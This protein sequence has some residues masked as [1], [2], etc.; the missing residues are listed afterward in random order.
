M[1][2]AYL[3]QGRFLAC[4]LLVQPFHQALHHRGLHVKQDVPP[5]IAGHH[6]VL[7]QEKQVPQGQVH[8]QCVAHGG[9][10]AQHAQLW[11]RGR[12]VRPLRECWADDIPSPA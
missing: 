7:Q 10:D 6:A 2:L 11:G 9:R 8:I 1:A 5:V 12:L 4:V 3:L